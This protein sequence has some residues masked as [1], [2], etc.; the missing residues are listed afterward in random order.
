MGCLEIRSKPSREGVG[1]AVLLGL[2][3]ADMEPTSTSLEA[4]FEFMLM[5]MYDGDGY[6]S[7]VLTD[8]QFVVQVPE[9]EK[10]VANIQYVNFLCIHLL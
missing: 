10:P 9:S 7:S 3:A 6:C 4:A 5:V 2:R 8:F 1:G